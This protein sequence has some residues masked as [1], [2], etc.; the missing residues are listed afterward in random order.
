VRHSRVVR[1]TVAA[2]AAVAALLVAGVASAATITKNVPSAGTFAVP[3]APA[4][5]AGVSG[6][7]PEVDPST[8]DA[9]PLEE[10]ATVH[11]GNSGRFDHHGRHGDH[12]QGANPKLLQSFEAL[13]FFDQRFANGGNQFS[14][15][16]P[17]QGLCVGKGK[18]VE[19]VNDVYQVFDTHGH[20]LTNPIDVNTLFGYPP[21]IVRSGP[22]AGQFGPEVFDMSCLYDSQTRTFFVV[23]SVLDRVGTTSAFSGDTS[24]DIGVA[25][26]PTSAY[27]FYR[28]NTTSD[29]AC[30]SDGV[31]PGPCFPDYPHVGADR[32]GFY[33]TTNVFD[34]FGPNFNGV[35]IYAMP[36]FLLASGAS[37]VPVT[38]ISTNGQGP[39]GPD[40]GT[41][42]TLIPAV[43]PDDQFADSG[44]GTEYFVSSRAVFTNDGTASSIVSWSL[45]NTKSLLSAT[46]NLQLTFSIINTGEYGV[47]APAT[48]KPGDVPLATCIGST[49]PTPPPSGPPCWSR[50]GIGFGGPVTKTENVLDAN[51]SRIGGVSYADG[52]LW[53]VLGS[54][55]TDS[56]GNP[57]GGV[58]WFVM[59]PHGMTTG[60][61][62]EGMLV[63]DGTNLTYPSIAATSSGDAAMGFT[64]VGQSD[65][66]SAGYAGLDAK[67]GAG[68]P[69]YAKRGAGPQDG[70]SEYAPFFADGSPRPRWGDY[71]AAVADGPSIWVASEYIGQTCTFNQY[72]QP[73]PTNVAAFGTCGDTRGALGNWDTR[74]SQLLPGGSFH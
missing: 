13:N 71:G 52:K 61:S 62:N 33:L 24:V 18:V 65:Y 9:D 5:Q 70:F 51:D 72:V 19:I 69:Q 55:A 23:G 38:L 59:N 60:L 67:G 31:N 48:Q 27:T 42:F 28:I 6:G 64:V 40:G 49:A 56:N 53:A 22:N 7:L 20:A 54:A 68:D 4:P 43:S 41:G 50:L 15:E 32:N 39:S 74:I 12:H 58:A 37:T 47:P 21:A 14:L 66:P 36:K 44:R 1:M 30:T 57:V 25:K 45:S 17:D 8:T 34:F 11:R 29:T 2:V 63:K 35:N 26:D 10:G 73:S 3:N 46:P 16:P